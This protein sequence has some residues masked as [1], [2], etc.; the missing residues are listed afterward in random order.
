MSKYKTVIER[1]FE[2]E[3]E[4]NGVN[5]ELRFTLDDLEEAIKTMGLEVR[6]APDIPY[7]YGAKR[8]LPE[9]IAGHGYTGIEVAENGDEAQ[10]MYKFAR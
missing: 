8:P 3:V 6:C 10:V 7:M 1:V 2:D 4:A 9:S 5:R